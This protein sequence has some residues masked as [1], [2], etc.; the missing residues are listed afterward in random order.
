[1]R[2]GTFLIAENDGELHIPHIATIYS[3]IKV[4]GK[5]KLLLYVIDD[6]NLF[7]YTSFSL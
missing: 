7:L 6:Y 3:T 2:L 5:I 1:M 4:F